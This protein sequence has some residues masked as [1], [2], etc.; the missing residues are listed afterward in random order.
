MA[1]LTKGLM[2][3]LLLVIFILLTSYSSALAQDPVNE[4]ELVGFI[5]GVVN[6][7][8]NANTLFTSQ[9]E[10]SS[11]YFKLNTEGSGPGDSERVKFNVLKIPAHYSL[12]DDK[13]A[14]VRPY[15]RAVL[16]QA[17][18][19][20]SVSP[21]EGATG[22]S[23]FSAVDTRSISLGGGADIELFDNFT[24]R[25]DFVATYSRIKNRYD[26]NND[27]S[28]LIGAFVDGQVF[29]WNM[30]VMTYTPSVRAQYVIPLETLIVTLRSS[31]SY[32]LNKSF[33]SSSDI[34][35]V[36]S[37][38]NLIRNGIIVEVPT[39]VSLFDTPISVRPFFSRSDL[40]GSAARA[41][42]FD[43]FY[44]VGGDLAFK[45]QDTLP[46]L[47]ELSVGGSYTWGDDMEGVRIGIGASF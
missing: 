8:V 20:E 22:L 43:Y 18:Q 44:E 31:Y 24:L 40:G 45:V 14:A 32:L 11:G 6:G 38:T 37:S 29:N 42:G 39:G 34:L 19:I 12:C 16:G 26:Y 4:E 27:V 46:L 7:L 13:D 15:I 3:S 36:D 23:D 1:F 35:N 28:L 5:N 2:K 47:S 30:D 21:T 10:V 9:E 25:P 17:S 33:S 41:L